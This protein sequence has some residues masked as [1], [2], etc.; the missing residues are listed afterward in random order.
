M[1][2]DGRRGFLKGLTGAA[3]GLALGGVRGYAAEE[4]A[5]PQEKRSRVAFV[6]GNDRRDMMREVLKPFEKD[7]REGI[8]GK[9]VVIKPNCVWDG[10]ALCAHASRRRQGVLDF[11]KPLPQGMVTVA[12]STASPKGTS[13]C[14][15]EYGYKP[16]ERDST[17]GL[18]T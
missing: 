7:I 18:W 12:E 3:A 2:I 16:I 6:T 10:N 8:R 13:N 4:K 9:R 5:R 11:L 17:P 15:E 1:N 14:F